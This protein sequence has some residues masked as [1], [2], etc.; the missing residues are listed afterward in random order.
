MN[1]TQNPTASPINEPIMIR[2]ATTNPRTIEENV[3]IVE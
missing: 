1:I 3:I 2:N